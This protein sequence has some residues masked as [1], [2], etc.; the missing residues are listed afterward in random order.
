MA[1]MPTKHHKPLAALSEQCKESVAV[2]PN[3]LLDQQYP[4]LSEKYGAAFNFQIQQRTRITEGRGKMKIEV[5]VPTEMNERYF[6]ALVTQE[7][8]LMDPAVF[9]QDENW[10]YRFQPRVG[11]Y[12][13][14]RSEALHE[15]LSA[16]LFDLAKKCREL[17]A[18]VDVSPLEF[19]FRKTS[20]VAPIVT[21]AMGIAAVKG[22]YWERPSLMVPVQN[23]IYEI[24]SE[25]LYPH[26]PDFHYRGVIAAAYSP[27]AQC[28]QWTD[29]VNG[30]LEHADDRVLLQ[31]VFGLLMIGRNLAQ[32]MVLMFGEA[33]SGKGTIARVMTSLVGKENTAM[34]RS[35]KLHERFE[36]GR[37]RHKLLL[38][39]PDVSQ[40]FLNVS[41]AYLLKSITGEDPISPEYKNS[42]AVPAAQPIH[43]LPL[44]TCNSRLRIRFEG[45]KEAW[46]RRLVPIQFSKSVSQEKRI[47]SLSEI[48]MER[49]GSGILNYAL[50]G[51]LLIAASDCDLALTERQRAVRDELLD[52][53]ESYVAF[54]REGLYEHEVG[55][56]TVNDAWR[57]YVEFCS[58]RG[59]APAT[60]RAFGGGFKQAVADL[61]GLTQRHDIKSGLG[62]DQRGW[63]GLSLID[64][65]KRRQ[66]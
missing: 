59:W 22:D 60:P 36:L 52:E 51:V 9:D 13:P 54:A 64:G 43:G 53:S 56:L 33:Q 11:F 46:R 35:D 50:Q 17:D 42:N 39:G 12:T 25:T 6:A 48:L 41:G 5:W 28:P 1:M 7:A 20:V 23:G 10:W 58:A 61:Y 65:R 45:D 2:T 29:F 3:D 4:G 8:N 55:Q 15:N 16:T 32:I 26:S 38:Y 63:Y 37:L 66:A 62:P 49:E 21:K 47:N 19:K 18:P 30:A 34:L 14:I 24:E 57:S 44:V 40:D 31:K 27:E